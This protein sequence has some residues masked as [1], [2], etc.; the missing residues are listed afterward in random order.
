MKASNARSM[1][2]VAIGRQTAARPTI[3]I[4]Y[5]GKN[6]YVTTSKAP[7][8]AS[9]ASITVRI[10]GIRHSQ[11]EPMMSITIRVAKLI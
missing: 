3:Q 11:T 5:Q 6:Q 10:V 7:N 2:S 9:V 1:R 4:I 8:V